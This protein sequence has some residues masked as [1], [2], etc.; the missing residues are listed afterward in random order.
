MRKK[1]KFFVVSD[2][3]GHY[4]ELRRDLNKA[5]F[6]QTNDD[7]MLIVCGDSFD[8]GEQ[9]YEVY[10]WLHK[11]VK[12]G[13]AIVLRG[14][15]TSFFE[16]VLNCSERGFNFQHNGVDKTIDS[17]MHRT[18]AFEM[19]LIENNLVWGQNAFDDFIKVVSDSILKEFPNIRE[20]LKSLPFYFE[21]EHYVFTHGMVDYT[22][23]DWHLS[24]WNECVWARPEDF[25]F[26]QNNTGKHLVVGHLN[27]SLV[28]W[29][30]L[31][32]TADGY[33]TYSYEP[34]N[35][36]YYDEYIDTY[37]LDSCSILSKRINVLVIEDFCD[38]S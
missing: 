16:G 24:D 17:F 32:L 26:Y 29:T 4:N 20:E 14:N 2:I 38:L 22:R 3:H 31:H 21:T 25:I 5:G 35:Q 13:K 36:I 15:H 9:S 6:R 11:L 8:R 33:D 23:P 27:S 28:K 30:R 19:Y 37:F 10:K 1:Y 18:K 7:H 12:K 34:D